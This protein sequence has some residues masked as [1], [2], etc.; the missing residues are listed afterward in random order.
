MLGLKSLKFL[1][2]M[3]VGLLFCLCVLPAVN[4]C[5]AA[6]AAAVQNDEAAIDI[7]HLLDFRPLQWLGKRR[8]LRGLRSCSLADE[9][10]QYDSAA[11][12][13][14]NLEFKLTAGDIE[15]LRLER[16]SR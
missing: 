11:L 3:L 7:C 10:L 5:E 13:G 16:E 15:R 12:C 8:P 1:A 14:D 6:N 2:V 4:E 9:I